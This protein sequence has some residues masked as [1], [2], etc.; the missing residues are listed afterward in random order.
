RY[1]NR[2]NR[3]AR[4]GPKARSRPARVPRHDRGDARELSVRHARRDAVVTDGVRAA[5]D[6][7]A[8]R[9]GKLKPRAAIVLGSGLAGVAEAVR[10]ALRIPYKEIPGFPEPGAPGHKGE[11][12]GGT[13]EGVPV[14]VQSG[15][16]HLYE[17]HAP[18]VAALPTRV[19]ARLGAT[20]LVVTN[21]AG[22]IRHTFRP[23]V[24]MLIAD[25]INLMFKNPLVGP[26]AE[27]DERFPDMS[28]PYD[29]ALRRLA[30]DVARTER[31]PLEEGVYAGLL[32][33]S[34]ETPA[35]IRILQ[36]IGADAVGMSTVPEVIAAR[37]RGIRRRAF[38]SLTRVAAG[39][40]AQTPPPRASAD[41]G[42][43]S[44]RGRA[45][46]RGQRASNPARAARGYGRPRRA[47]SPTGFG[48]VRGG[49]PR[50]RG[51]SRRGPERFAIAQPAHRGDQPARH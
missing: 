35:E 10:D 40:P 47:A 51:W 50:R 11:L 27:G 22:G 38:S 24:L 7:V 31:I 26:V 45:G 25:H 23:P 17:G 19:F 36:R 1:P 37:A 48:P 14:V 2:R 33:P 46:A 42:P 8:K 43:A 41:G 44:W 49:R 30:R 13:L 34:F 12:V 15:R 9:L 20:T 29:P 21:A 4:P 18:E 32:G 6:V 5:T 28:D 39:L 3:R 16:F